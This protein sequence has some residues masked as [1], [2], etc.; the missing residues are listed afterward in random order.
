MEVR[1]PNE[2]G[3]ILNI[4]QGI[5]NVEVRGGALCKT[6][7]STFNIKKSPAKNNGAT[8]NCV[9]RKSLEIFI[10]N[11]ETKLEQFAAQRNI[12]RING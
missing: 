12:T 4:E 3:G 5:L 9:L 8:V 2:S 7:T 10:Q 6:I 11:R 1:Y